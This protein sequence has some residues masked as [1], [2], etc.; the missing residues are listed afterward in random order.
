ML[1]AGFGPSERVRAHF[2]I[3]LLVGRADDLLVTNCLFDQL[4][5]PRTH[6]FFLCFDVQISRDN[7]ALLPK[8]QA[9]SR[10]LLNRIICIH[11]HPAKPIGFD[12]DA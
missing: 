12:R 11:L 1:S 10:R 7:D 5:S 8:L 9:S 6:L 2:A 4:K 3:V